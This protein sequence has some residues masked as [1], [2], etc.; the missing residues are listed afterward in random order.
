[1]GNTVLLKR[2]KKKMLSMPRKA[3]SK[4]V[5]HNIIIGSRSIII[6][7]PPRS[8]GQ[9]GLYEISTQSSR[10]SPHSSS[11]YAVCS[12][13]LLKTMFAFFTSLTR[14]MIMMVRNSSQYHFPVTTPFDRV[15]RMVCPSPKLSQWHGHPFHHIGSAWARRVA[16]IFLT[17]PS[18]A[19]R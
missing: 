8:I 17:Y 2:A 9:Y 1:M 16:T 13:S 14:N 3:A 19:L 12:H 5:I 6:V 7:S 18:D 10:P 11:A 4:T 15:K